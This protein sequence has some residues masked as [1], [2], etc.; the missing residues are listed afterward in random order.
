M[1]P[2]PACP[3]PAQIHRLCGRSFFCCFFLSFI[4][5]PKKGQI[6]ELPAP[7]KPAAGSWICLAVFLLGGG[8]NERPSPAVTPRFTRKR[9]VPACFNPAKAFQ[10]KGGKK[11]LPANLY[12]LFLTATHHRQLT[13]HRVTRGTR[14]SGGGGDEG[15]AAG[16]E[17][18]KVALQL[19]CP[20]PHQH[21]LTGGGGLGGGSGVG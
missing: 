6:S 20:V 9:T 15:G 16:R 13:E 2:V 1:P 7:A 4:F 21:F 18:G 3:A 10:R 5:L 8:F 12:F 19:H 17:S 14:D 11:K